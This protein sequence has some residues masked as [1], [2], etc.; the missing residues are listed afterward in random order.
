MADLEVLLDPAR[1]ART[2]ECPAGRA[3]L[4]LK[5][6]LLFLAVLSVIVYVMLAC[7]R[8][9]YPYE[10]EWME[11]GIVDHIR[12]ILAGRSLYVEPSLEFIPNIYGPVYFYLGAGLCKIMGVGFFPLRLISFVSSLGCFW[13]I[14][15]IVR[16]ETGQWT[17]AIISVGLYAASFRATGAWMDIARVDSLFLLLALAAIY[18]LR[19]RTDTGSMVIAGILMTLSFLTKQAALFIAL[20]LVLYTLLACRG[21]ARVAFG[22][23]FLGLVFATTRLC[24]AATGGWYSYYLLNLPGQHRFIPIIWAGF[25]SVDIGKNAP[26][27]LAMTFFAAIL[28]RFIRSRREVGFYAMLLIGMV[29][30]AYLSR[31]HEGGGENV[32]MPALAA[33][34]I[35]FSLG[36]VTLLS[37]FDVSAGNGS[38]GNGPAIRRA[39]LAAVYLAGIWQF[40]ILAYLPGQ[41][42]PRNRDRRS[43]DA[44]IKTLARLNGD[45]LMM[46]H[47]FLQTLTGRNT[48]HVHASALWGIFQGTDTKLISRLRDDFRQ[49]IVTGKY[50]AIVLDE[51]R[52]GKPEY[53]Q[54]FGKKY[55]IPFRDFKGPSFLE[56][57]RPEIEQNYQCI[58]PMF[59]NDSVFWPVTGWAVRPGQIYV[60]KD[61]IVA[62]NLP[63]ASQPTAR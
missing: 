28:G 41:Q 23:T 63:S 8:M 1:E 15:R 36:A 49:A 24:D 60:R 13:L 35:S 32:L 14:G 58:G 30:S 20:P 2:Q 39:L 61:K 52:D 31:I 38:A 51:M 56:L 43:G 9:D 21:W 37:A 29:G 25:W 3:G 42:V 62:T 19:F 17:W 54:E 18:L 5:Y 46:E 22:V 11:G 59:P 4:L 34:A 57:F 53:L 55:D 12:W 6:L 27:A 10:L 7:L 48:F 50:D 33:L 44:M 45:V 16:R 40:V 26:I 47:G